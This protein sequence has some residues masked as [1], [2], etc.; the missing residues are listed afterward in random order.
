MEAVLDSDNLKRPCHGKNGRVGAWVVV[1][2]MICAAWGCGGV[3][4][5]AW[6]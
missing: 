1:V 6:L 3:L 5:G 4:H 2:G